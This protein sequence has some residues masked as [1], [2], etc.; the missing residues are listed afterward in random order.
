LSRAH[1]RRREHQS[2]SSRTSGVRA[3][4]QV[5]HHDRRARVTVDGALKRRQSIASDKTSS[6]S[7]AATADLDFESRPCVSITWSVVR[8]T[9]SQLGR[10]RSRADVAS[11]LIRMP[12]CESSSPRCRRQPLTLLCSSR[13]FFC[14]RRKI[15]LR[16]KLASC[17]DTVGPRAL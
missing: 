2:W 9:I 10:A 4:R 17:T 8:S 6:F 5:D 12:S 15:E 7:A 13:K 11:S 14:G 16:T 1:S 3:P